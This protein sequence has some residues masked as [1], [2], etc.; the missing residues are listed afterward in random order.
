MRL[1]LN[2][3]T[4]P[5]DITYTDGNGETA[6]YH[7]GPGADIRVDDTDLAGALLATHFA[8]TALTERA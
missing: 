1:F 5:L 2:D 4:D 8:A 3:T 7:L 6:I